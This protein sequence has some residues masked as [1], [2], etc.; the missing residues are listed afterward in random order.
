[1]EGQAYREEHS[2]FRD[3]RIYCPNCDARRQRK[4]FEWLLFAYLAMGTAGLLLFLT[5]SSWRQ[6]GA[7]LVNLFF[8][9]VFLLAAIVPHELGHAFTARLFGLEVRQVLVG[10]GS[11]VLR[12]G[13]F[14]FPFEFRR[15]PFGGLALVLPDSKPNLRT[16]W[17]FMVLAGPAVNFVLASIA[18]FSFRSTFDIN[19]SFT[20]GLNPLGLFLLA[21][22]IVV[23]E[24]LVPFRTTATQGACHSDGYQLI[25]L[26]FGEGVLAP[27]IKT[28]KARAVWH[29]VW[30]WVSALFLGFCALLLFG[31][32]AFFVFAWK[33]QWVERIMLSVPFFLMGS[34]L[35]WAI[36]R[37]ANMPMAPANGGSAVS[38]ADDLLS[39]YFPLTQSYTEDIQRISEWPATVSPPLFCKQIQDLLDSE[40]F[41]EAGERLRRCLETEPRNLWMQVTYA[42]ILQTLKHYDEAATYYDQ[43]LAWGDLSLGS[44]TILKSER[45]RMS[46]LG[47]KFEKAAIECEEFL[48]QTDSVIAK[49]LMLDLLASLPHSRNLPAYLHEADKWSRRALEIAP[50]FITLKGT[51]AS[52]LADLGRFAE[53]KPLLTEVFE[54]SESNIDKGTASVY[55][56]L[57]ARAE[58]DLIT[59]RKLAKQA[60]RIHPEPWLKKRIQDEGLG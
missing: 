38:G 29:R 15:V 10:F 31:L 52:V 28:P 27:K 50:G 56:A 4:T 23:I 13:L 41:V 16:R 39:P 7:V 53:A 54:Q 17:F 9:Q 24:N 25:S 2:L 46:V 36:Y 35:C 22:L 3:R 58:G 37:R 43:L 48:S 49:A 42:A 33:G 26:L 34:F 1:M 30:K 51:R 19:F 57:C 8:L 59:A 60:A 11:P 44:K 32:C 45:V 14:G 12:C 6:A 18:Y 47:G 21:N 40:D 20:N 5:G 55:L